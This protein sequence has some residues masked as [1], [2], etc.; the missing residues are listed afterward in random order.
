MLIGLSGYAQVGKDSVGRF[1]V[2]DHGFTRYAFAD[3]LRSVLYALNPVLIVERHG[4]GEEVG[5]LQEV[6]DEA[7]WEIAKQENPEVRRLL[8]AM[9]TEAG[10]KI[11]GEDVW[12][13]A[14]FNKI[15]EDNV[16]IT[17]VRFPN[18]AQR[19]KAEGGYVVRVNRPGVVAVNNHPSEVALDEWGFDYTVPNVGALEDLRE[20]TKDL[21][22]GLHLMESKLTPSVRLPGYGAPTA[23]AGAH[24]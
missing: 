24:A 11:L 2:E 22:V 20:I 18:E 15:E 16:V 19:V 17:D 13:N 21:I 3:V 6:V 9:G 7:T 4:W 12:V 10:R 5:R 1:L 23:K 8:Q 14:V